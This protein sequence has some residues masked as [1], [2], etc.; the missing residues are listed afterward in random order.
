MS[1]HETIESLAENPEQL[2]HLYQEALKAGEADA[3]RQAIEAHYQARPDNLLYAAWFHRLC[4]QP[5]QPQRPAVAWPWVIPLS[6]CN[7]L[8]F[9][10]LSAD[11]FTLKVTHVQHGEYGFMPALVLWATPLAAIFVLIYLAGVGRRRWWLVPPVGVGLIA[12]VSYVLLTYPRMGPRPFR[13]QYLTLMALHLPLLSWAGVGV[14]LTLGRHDPLHRFS[15]LLKSLEVFVVGGLLIGAGSLFIAITNGLFM[16]LDIEL[17]EVVKRLL[18]AGGGGLIPVLAT[19]VTYDPRMPPGQQA[20][21]EGLSKL[22]ALLLRL[23]LPLTGLVLIA[24]LAFVPFN[25]RAPFDNREVL[26]SHNAMLFAVVA[27]LVGVTPRSTDDVLPGLARWLRRG[28]VALAALALLVG[29]HALAAMLY[30]TAL[31]GLTPNRLTFIGWNIINIGL[32]SLVLGS[33]VRAREGQWIPALH[34]A[35]RVGT[36]A[37]ACWAL[38]MLLL[39]PWLFSA[40]RQEIAGLPPSVQQVVEEYPT[41]ILLKCHASPHIYLLEGGKKRW[42]DTIETFEQRGYVWSDVHFVPCAD[43]RAIPDG[44]PIPPDAGPPPQP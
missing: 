10:A 29:L 42:I 41:P 43:L 15:F 23:L 12:A 20:F 1:Y 14:F 6:L 40:D 30:R 26:I 24:Y 38:A 32:L 7:G 11:R 17:P 16:A 5:A 21:G 33:Q 36:V 31:D 4:R 9:W 27:L 25:F 35:Y 13:E 8:L 37:Y 18:F 34:R 28:I 2:E 19:A 3:F 44:V 22:L 39:L